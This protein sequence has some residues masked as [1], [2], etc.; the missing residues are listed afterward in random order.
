MNDLNWKYRIGSCLCWVVL[1]LVFWALLVG[2]TLGQQRR[3]SGV[4]GVAGPETTE[5]E[6]YYKAWDDAV[7]G[8]A[9]AIFVYGDRLEFHDAA[10]YTGQ[11]V[12]GQWWAHCTIW[13]W[14]HPPD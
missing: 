10:C 11:D 14:I 3:L 7:E 2:L 9:L 4:T 8:Y 5:D 12:Y 6:A 13:F 1:P